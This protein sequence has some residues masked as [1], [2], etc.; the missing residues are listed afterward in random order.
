MR[1]EAE[2]VWP[3]FWMPALTRNGSARSRSASANTTCGDLPPSSSVT[4]AT[5]RAAAACTSAP[6]RN[7]PGEGEMPDA[8]MGGERRAGLFAE[9]RH[10]VERAVRKARLAREIGER[11]RG[12]AGFLRRLQH[13]GVAH[14]QRRADRAPGDL[15]RIVPRHDMPGHAMRLAQG[16]DRVAVEIGDGFAHHL[17]G[18]AAVKLHVAGERQ[19]VRASPASRACRRRAPRSAPARRRGRRSVRRVSPAAARARSR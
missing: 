5:W 18:G 7:R 8:G 13:A 16:V 2:Q 6:D 19:R 10:D 14:R 1:E 4:G 11:K 15:H 17:V 3:A 12:Q 9:A